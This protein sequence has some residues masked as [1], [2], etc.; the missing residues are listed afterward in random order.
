M[1]AA[2]SFT[3]LRKLFLPF[4]PWILAFTVLSIFSTPMLC[5]EALG[6]DELSAEYEH[7]ESLINSLAKTIGNLK[8]LG[9]DLTT[10]GNTWN[11]GTN[12]ELIE[13]NKAASGFD[14]WVAE[15]TSALQATADAL[16]LEAA[17]IKQERESAFAE[18]QTRADEM[19]KRV[20]ANIALID[21]HRKVNEKINEFIENLNKII[22]GAN[23]P[24]TSP[25]VQK[26]L[27]EQVEQ[28]KPELEQ[29]KADYD[30]VTEQIA[31]ENEYLKN[32]NEAVKA[33]NDRLNAEY[34][35]LEAET[36]AKG[37]TFEEANQEF[38]QQV[39]LGASHA[40]E[41]AES[42]KNEALDR[43][44]KNVERFKEMK[45]N[46]IAEYSAKYGS[47]LATCR[48]IL[49][50]SK[51]NPN[52]TYSIKE[53]FD[54]SQSGVAALSASLDRI[55]EL[56]TLLLGGDGA[57][58]VTLTEEE[59]SALSS[60]LMKDEL[61]RDMANFNLGMDWIN[62]FLKLV[63][64]GPLKLAVKWNQALIDGWRSTNMAMV[65]IA[66][67]KNCEAIDFVLI[68]EHTVNKA[69][70]ENLYEARG[71]K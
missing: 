58:V 67:T 22:G 60:I 27:L 9:E 36:K 62:K 26:K 68:D 57:D 33:E 4:R 14:A 31:V 15:K 42:L 18:L 29:M 71:C 54:I 37:A 46:L 48:A 25:K 65:N 8:K 30:L 23:D 55:G 56:K 2:S 20:N 13:A 39:S 50:D 1:G 32:E 7:F 59:A 34:D 53:N 35:A 12:P 49:Q 11:N 66:K 52:Q 3:F 41:I 5:S 64:K 16:N 70:F 61:L 10:F 43:N 47:L 24:N 17:A 40:A 69:F 19:N 44:K 63:V 45:A 6:K 51:D 38:A 28:L 21:D